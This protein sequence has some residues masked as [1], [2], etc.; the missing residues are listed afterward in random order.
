MLFRSVTPLSTLERTWGD[1]IFTNFPD[2][3]YNVVYGSRERRLQML[4]EDVDIY[5]INHDGLK[6]PGIAEALK[7]RPDIDLIIVDEIAQ[8][9][10]NAGTDRFRALNTVVN[11]Q[12]PRR[13]W[14]LTGT[15]TP[16]AP[17][18]AWAQCRLLV[19]ERV[20]QYFNRF[21]ERVMRQISQYV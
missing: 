10:R 17:T 9:A 19:P 5:L 21:K 12:V 16:N 6:V 20:P 7:D 3:S 11:K 4:E 13:A 2:I 15:P 1:E 18:D 14:G 8:A